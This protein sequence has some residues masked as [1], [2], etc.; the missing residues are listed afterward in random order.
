MSVFT[1]MNSTP[2]TLFSTI[3]FTALLP[4]PPVPSTRISAPGDIS[5]RT[6][7]VVTEEAE[8]A[9]ELELLLLE[10]EKRERSVSDMGMGVINEGK[11]EEGIGRDVPLGRLQRI[12]EVS[13]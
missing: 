9:P 8:C 10:P 11:R 5:G 12:T 6:S 3:R 2:W 7:C 13:S 1:A 4:A